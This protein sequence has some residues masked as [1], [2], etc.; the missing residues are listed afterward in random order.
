VT[1]HPLRIDSP[2]KTSEAEGV[3]NDGEVVALDTKTGAIE[4]RHEFPGSPV[5]GAT[6]SVNDVVFAT[7]YDGHVYA[8]DANSGKLLWQEALP[9]GVNAGVAVAGD[10]AIVPAGVATSQGQTAM[11]VAYRLGG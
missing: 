2:W 7:T 5:F 6:T 10:T 9:A 4:W 1:N 3:R 11:L 8:L